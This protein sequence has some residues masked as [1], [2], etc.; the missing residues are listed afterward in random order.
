VSSMR[1]WG[2]NRVDDGGESGSDARVAVIA[3]AYSEC[4][5][6]GSGDG[7]VRGDGDGHCA[8]VVRRR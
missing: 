4:D 3:T 1:W 7:G 2:D 8:L 6:D 5:C